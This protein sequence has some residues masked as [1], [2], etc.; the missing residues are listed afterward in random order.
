MLYSVKGEHR[1]PMDHQ[2]TSKETV[3]DISAATA[4][5]RYAILYGYMVPDSSRPSRR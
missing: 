5:L 4:H 1:A 2:A 3:A